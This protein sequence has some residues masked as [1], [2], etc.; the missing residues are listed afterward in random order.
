MARISQIIAAQGGVRAK[1]EGEATETYK[2]I[3]R[4][5]QLEG[6]SRV[7]RP[8]AEDGE[9]LPP[10]V[11]RVQV[12][13]QD[14][15]DQTAASL[16]R[17]FDVTFTL[18]CANQ[19]ARADV[20]VDGHTVVAQAPVSFLL[21]LEKQLLGVAA[22]VKKLPTLDVAENWTFDEQSAVWKTEPVETHRTKKVFRNHLV[23]P[24]TEKHAAQVNTY[25]EDETVGYWTLVKS[26]GA[27]PQSRVTE[28]ADR[29]HALQT[30]VKH[31]REE[32][33]SIEAHQK[34]VGEDLFAWLFA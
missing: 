5:Q 26:S 32:A 34:H 16:A 13:A 12:R 9:V 7:Y 6:L 1:A 33:N 27:L 2:M 15:I 25:T 23:A 30:A 22:F 31:A 8:K 28:L 18:D 17:L 14:A 21:F 24:A 11:K 3:Q 29:V 4:S 10:E 19:E 20:V